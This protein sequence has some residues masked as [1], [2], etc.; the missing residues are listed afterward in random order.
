MI[1]LVIDDD[2]SSSL[3]VKIFLNEKYICHRRRVCS[4]DVI[5]GS[6]T[7]THG[8]YYF[9]GSIQ[10]FD[11][12]FY[13]EQVHQQYV[14]GPLKVP[15]M[16]LTKGSGFHEVPYLGIMSYF[17]HF[18]GPAFIFLEMLKC[19][20]KEDWPSLLESAFNLLSLAAIE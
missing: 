11:I 16:V 17:N 5:F 4:H 15:G 12:V 14:L 1:T 6:E 9:A 10:M 2:L 18:G 3:H 7:E 20:T 8:I 19:K 13:T